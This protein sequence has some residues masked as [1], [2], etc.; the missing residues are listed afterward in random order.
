[1]L[2]T[3]PTAVTLSNRAI[4]KSMTIIC[5]GEGDHLTRVPINSDA[6]TRLSVVIRHCP[7]ILQNSGG[8]ASA[9]GNFRVRVWRFGYLSCRSGI[10]RQLGYRS[11]WVDSSSLLRVSSSSVIGSSGRVSSIFG[12]VPGMCVRELGHFTD[13][14]VSK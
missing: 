1:M 7:I 11:S 12:F 3:S 5:V 6:G 9:L 4:N 2:E 8:G 13:R 10:G 14:Y